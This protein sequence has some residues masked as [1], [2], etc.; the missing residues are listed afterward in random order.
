VTVLKANRSNVKK[1][2]RNLKIFVGLTLVIY[3]VIL[4]VDESNEVALIKCELDQE[5]D[6]Y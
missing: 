1:I 5:C 4:A 2:Y 3:A 6:K